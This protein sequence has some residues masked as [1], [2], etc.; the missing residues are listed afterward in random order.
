[1]F[2]LSN[3]RYTGAKTKLLASLNEIISHHIS[4]NAKNNI[5]LDLFG[6]TGVVSEF[7][8]K[9]KVF[10]YFIIN[11]FLYSNHIIYQGFLEQKEFDL[12]KLEEIQ[13]NYNLLMQPNLNLSFNKTFFL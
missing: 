13:K 10:D 2:K 3:R 9:G 4:F 11:D 1:M 5:F 8:I 12:K 6:G 7:F